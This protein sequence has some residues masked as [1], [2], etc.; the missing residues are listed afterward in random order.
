M[1][2]PNKKSKKEP[3]K[4]EEEDEGMKKID[5][6]LDAEEEAQELEDEEELKDVE[7][8]DPNDVYDE[9]GQPPGD[10]IDVNSLTQKQRARYE[11]DNKRVFFL[12]ALSVHPYQDVGKLAVKK[13]KLQD[14]GEAETCIQVMIG[15]IMETS[16]DK[17]FP[18][19]V[20][21]YFNTL[22]PD[23]YPNKATLDADDINELVNLTRVLEDKLINQAK[24]I[25]PDTVFGPEV[26]AQ[27]INESKEKKKLIM[28][29]EQSAA[30][31][32]SRI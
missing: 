11:R 3:P 7:E 1:S 30:S 14:K 26:N 31:T 13:C 4:K 25:D 10:I 16:D 19:R 8:Y 24:I 20:L 15:M 29:D 2:N 5:E 17:D 18:A 22:V 23:G 12:K 28:M 32:A 9:E 27:T 21:K 6:A